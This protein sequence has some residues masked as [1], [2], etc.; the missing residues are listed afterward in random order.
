MDL[1]LFETNLSRIKSLHSCEEY[2]V[3]NHNTIKL[4]F[5]INS[6]ENIDQAKY[7]Y[8]M[9][10]EDFLDST[11]GRLISKGTTRQLPDAITGLLCFFASYF[12]CVKM[13]S[14]LNEISNILSFGKKVH[15]QKRIASI[16]EFYNITDVSHDYVDKFNKIHLLLFPAQDQ[17]QD[18][19]PEKSS[20]IFFAYFL[21]GMSELIAHDLPAN[22]HIFKNLFA[23][24]EI[25]KLC[26]ANDFQ[27][28]SINNIKRINGRIVDIN[29]VVACDLLKTGSDL[30]MGISNKMDHNYE[31]NSI[32]MSNDNKVIEQ[33][34][35]F[36]FNRH[37][38]IPGYIENILF[39][40]FNA[41]FHPDP[42]GVILGL[43]ATPEF[44]KIYLG[45][46]FPRSYIELLNIS[47]N[48]LSQS[49]IREKIA[50]DNCIKILDIGS[51]TGGCL[52]G[53]LESILRWYET[54]CKIDIV[55]IDGNKIS[56]D[57][58]NKIIS[59]FKN[60]K[61]HHQINFKTIHFRFSFES[62]FFGEELNDILM[63]LNQQYDFIL[64]SKFISE[65][66]N[67]D[68]QRAINSY[69]VFCDIASRYLSRW[70][71]L[72]LN[73]ITS[74]DNE[75]EWIPIIVNRETNNFITNS[76]DFS[77]VLPLSCAHWSSVCQNYNNC[78][79]QTQMM[80]SH[81]KKDRD[82]SKIFFKVIGN[83]TYAHAILQNTNQYMEYQVSTNKLNPKKCNGGRI[84][85]DNNENTPSA[86]FFNVKD[87]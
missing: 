21:T 23:N 43:D 61:N 13:R 83:K 46:Y 8:D 37:T 78:Y 54:K 45:T 27:N 58:Q 67:Y 9:F 42:A 57:F 22:A 29:K 26:F 44:L 64:S 63:N 7:D 82:I 72:I 52:L 69:Y 55:S 60:L 2:I 81:C 36:E 28:Y 10:F 86:F 16:Y 1:N 30:I 70:G 41:I 4:L 39:N 31:F 12:Y 59:K 3:D 51:G 40:D 35:N 32:D 18:F 71:L 79:A 76:N 77:F 56:L 75:V 74:K 25:N 50:S 85:P 14:P 19:D 53:L 5:D 80:I 68:Y 15:I 87:S 47:D 66:Y 17:P 20:N 24:S 34:D 38:R 73:D 48:L 11:V 33:S 65:F 84:I 49:V 6:G 62:I